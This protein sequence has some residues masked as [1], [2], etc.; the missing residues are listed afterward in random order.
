MLS[1]KFQDGNEKKFREEFFDRS[2]LPIRG[3]LFLA[4]ILY[5]LFAALDTWALPE[6]RNI[7]WFIRFGIVCPLLGIAF[8]VTYF[9][10]FKQHMQLAL[11]LTSFAVGFGI[12]AMIA[13]ADR[14]EPGFTSYYAGLILVIMWNYTM[15]RLY[16]YYATISSL[17]LLLAYE[18]VTILHH[19]M[20]EG[21]MDSPLTFVFINNNF[22]L[23]SSSVIS[24]YIG[25]TFETY[26][27][28]AFLQERKIN[29]AYEE[30]K[31]SQ[32]Q[33]VQAEKEASLGQLVAGIAHEINT[34]VGIGVTAASHLVEITDDVIRSFEDRTARKEDMERYF[35]AAKQNGDLLLR[36]LKK[37]AELVKSF[38][39]VA[40]DQT[41]GERRKFNVKSYLEDIIFSLGPK[42]KKSPHTVRIKC[43]DDYYIDSYPGAFAQVVT[44]LLINAI[45]HAYDEREKGDIDIEVAKN[46]NNDD[47]TLSLRDGGKGISKENLKKIFDPF[48]TTNRKGGGTGLGLHIVANIVS[49]N[50]KGKI[51][52]E[53]EVGRGTTFT[54]TL[55]MNA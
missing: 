55:P 21:G 7:A 23:L 45:L 36:N 41:S 35:E 30:L 34:P 49:Q 25:F 47:M 28:N 27:R 6:T 39:M 19:G 8:C 37:T 1:L 54:I 11:S 48:F 18:A 5:A 9:R 29:R 33:L 38:K 12:L 17:T 14:N 32:E 15:L 22:F 26:M 16:F 46:R 53:S 44:N 13:I 40:V 43:P 2:L 3:G 50:L 52:C 20:L 24:M 4:L 10:F 42:L 51:V 31:Q